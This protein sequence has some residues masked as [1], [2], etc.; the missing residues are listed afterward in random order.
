MEPKVTRIIPATQHARINRIQL[1]SVRGMPNNES[2]YHAGPEPLVVAKMCSGQRRQ[3]ATAQT[4]SKSAV[5][6]MIAMTLLKP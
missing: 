5:N 2:Q 4:P 3:S 6:A 1:R